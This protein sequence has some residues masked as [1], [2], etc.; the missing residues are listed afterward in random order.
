MNCPN[1]RQFLLL[2]VT[3]CALGSL[4]LFS[5][6]KGNTSAAAVV[7]KTV[8][9][10]PHVQAYQTR[11]DPRNADPLTSIL[12]T[13]AHWLPLV[14]PIGTERTTDTVYG[15]ML[16]DSNTLYVAF[17]S[18]K[19][20]TPCTQDVVSVYLD[21]SRQHDGSEIM[22][23]AVNSVGH[24]SCMWIRDAQP[25]TRA[26]D[27]GT[28]ETFHPLSKI[29]A[30]SLVP[31][32]FT[33]TA[34]GMQNGQPVWTAVIAIPMQKLPRPLR[35]VPTAGSQWKINLL[36]TTLVGEIS[37]NME[38]LQANLSPVFVG[39]QAVAPYRMATLNLVDTQVSSAR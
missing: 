29:P 3:L 33:H 31:E 26:K 4:A 1:A 36:R 14:S 20:M 38:P 18:Q 25:P 12:W 19:P 34:Q 7:D 37:A 13:S 6:C 35:A 11:I 15:A 17:V 32:L 27:D 5:G 23:F 24:T 16:F 30:D 21:S 9:P 8:S 28:P 39:Q 2:C 10:P 22:Q